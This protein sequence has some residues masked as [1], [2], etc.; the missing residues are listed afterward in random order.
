MITEI[1]ID[2]LRIFQQVGLFFAAV[3]GL[4]LAIW[5]SLTSH[6]QAVASLEQSKTA[7]KQAETASRQAE[8]AENNQRFDRY[9][10]AAQM[11]DNDKSAVRQAG[12]YLLRELAIGDEK[13]RDLCSEL[14]ASFIRS[15]L[16]DVLEQ[17][18][19]SDSDAKKRMADNPSAVDTVDAFKSLC[20]A[21]GAKEEINLSNIVLSKFSLG[22]PASLIKIDLSYSH[23]SQLNLYRMFIKDC[24]FSRTLFRWNTVHQTSFLENS[25]FN[26]PFDK[27][28]FEDVSFRGAEFWDCTFEKWKFKN[29]DLTGVKFFGDGGQGKLPFEAAL[30]KDCWAWKGNLPQI[31]TKFS[32]TIYDPGPEGKER[33][34]FAKHWESRRVEGLNYSDIPPRKKL[35]VQLH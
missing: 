6:R 23:L 12:I 16:A 35:K 9:A 18:G 13:Y 14:L 30:L 1:K 32:G 29:C 24:D 25:F 28:D 11:L 2:R 27:V 4:A 5:R 26:T 10:R 3:I 22:H 7:I 21:G 19:E 34:S 31:G 33:I 17:M 15:R 20:R 8:I